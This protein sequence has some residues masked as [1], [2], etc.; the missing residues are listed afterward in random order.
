LSSASISSATTSMANDR[1]QQLQISLNS[2]SFASATSDPTRHKDEQIN[3]FL[4]LLFRI[5]AN[6]GLCFLQWG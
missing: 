3:H 2:G 4:F 5:I 6:F 1:R